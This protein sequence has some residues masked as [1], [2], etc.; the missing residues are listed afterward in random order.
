M[1]GIDLTLLAITLAGVA[2]LLVR[3]RWPV[4]LSRLYL[5]L[6]SAGLIATFAVPVKPHWQAVPL[7]IAL[8]VVASHLLSRPRTRS[9]VTA[10]AAILLACMSLALLWTTP[11]FHLPAPTGVYAVGTTGPLQWIDSSRTLRG[12]ASPQGRRRELVVQVWYPVASGWQFGKRASYA[13]RKELSLAR[14]YEAS[15][16]TNS[17]LD[18]P[19]A[20]DGAP[21]PVLLF[22]HRWGGSRTQDTFLVEELASHGY[23]VVA[24]DHPLNAARMLLADGS[25]VKSDR[26]DAL[27]NLEA[28]SAQAIA[29][30]WQQ[31]L[32][33]WTADDQF[34]LNQLQTNNAGWFSNRLDFTRV[35]AFGHSFGGASSLALLGVDRRIRCAVNMDGWTFQGLDHRTTEPVMFV[36]EGVSE[37]R[38]PERGVEGALDD[39][40]NAAVDASLRRFGGWRA[41][42]MGTQHLD[43]TDQ[44]LLSPLQRLTHTGPLSGER[45]RGITRGLV[46]GFFD[47]TLKGQGQLPSYPEVH[48]QRFP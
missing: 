40:D 34:V 5:A 7:Y 37:V 8:L 27:S 47:Q 21:Y 4:L 41:Y 15:I 33:L 39:Y 35:G 42:V 9:R 10:A 2:G 16:L 32:A 17:L 23:V 36:Y 20:E 31:E 19:I 12:D 3:Q 6:A 14:S 43:F 38:Y 24:I 29:A 45:V 44:T 28:T 46:L 30:M 26:A 22:G 25:V 13:R 18:A 11:M 48:L 1:P